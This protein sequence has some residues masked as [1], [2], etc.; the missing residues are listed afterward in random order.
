VGATF[1]AAPEAAGPHVVLFD[2]AHDDLLEFVAA[3]AGERVLGVALADAPEAARWAVLDA[4][5]S[6]VVAAADWA[7]RPS[8]AEEKLTRWARIDE[9]AASPAVARRLVGG[10]DVWRALVRDVVE[11]G[12]FTTSPVLVTGPTG[13][14]KEL[15]ARAIH[16]LDQR[17]DKG[18]FVVVDCT[19]IVESLSGSEFFGHEKGAFTGAYATRDGAFALADGG[20]LFLDE[21]G[22]L[23]L[24]LQAELLR[25]VQEGTYKRVGGNSWRETSFRLVCATNRDLTRE[26]EA[27]RFRADLYY[28]IAAWTLETPPLDRRRDDIRALATHFLATLSEGPP[29]EVDAAV[30]DHLE[31]RDYPGNVREL[32]HLVTR[33][34]FR[35]SGGIVT[36]G[37]VPADERPR[38]GSAPVRL[39]TARSGTSEARPAGARVGS[40]A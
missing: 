20:T 15:V 13:T 17:P 16:D 28:R 4:G 2:G 1:D 40:R 35:H 31:R 21:I 30:W 11:A 12:F 37:D 22:E 36:I 18:P 32:K 14:G 5:A 29:P 39:D 34:F 26:I 38:G 6:D 24:P 25:V 23:P 3:R 10:S 7:R 33:M 9:L 27:G 19:T 8:L